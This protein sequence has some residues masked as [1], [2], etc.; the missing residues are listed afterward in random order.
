MP[1][2]LMAHTEP[3]S[4]GQGELRGDLCSSTSF[5]STL[6]TQGCSQVLGPA[7]WTATGDDGKEV[8]HLS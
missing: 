4:L 1:G 3:P 2:V 5:L 8:F 7:A 6:S